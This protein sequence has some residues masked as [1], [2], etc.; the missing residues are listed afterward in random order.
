MLLT[1]LALNDGNV[2]RTSRASGVA[3]ETLRRWKNGQTEEETIRLAEYCKE[4]LADLIERR[5]YQICGHMTDEKMAAAGIGE[6]M[7]AATKGIDKMLVLRGEA[8]RITE[9]LTDQQRIDRVCELLDRARVRA[10]T[11]GTGGSDS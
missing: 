10:L 4:H 8:N 6:L 3:R 11:A 7:T 5:V 1:E 2:K 9:N